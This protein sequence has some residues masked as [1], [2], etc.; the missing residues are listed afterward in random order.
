M[1]LKDKQYQNYA[2]AEK[3]VFTELKKNLQYKK[4]QKNKKTKQNKTHANH[5][6]KL[7][8]LTISEPCSRFHD[9]QER[10]CTHE[11][12]SRSGHMRE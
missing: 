4:K 11:V 5:H 7:L 12:G 10:R 1:F 9:Q 2:V 3:N 6:M 8:P